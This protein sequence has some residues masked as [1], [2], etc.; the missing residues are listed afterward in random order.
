MSYDLK[1]FTIVEVGEDSWGIQYTGGPLERGF[2][3]Y[4]DALYTANQ[5]AI[6]YHSAD[7]DAVPRNLDQAILKAQ[8]AR[9][10]YIT[11]ISENPSA[12]EEEKN[13]EIAKIAAA[14]AYVSEY[15]LQLDTARL[16]ATAKDSFENQSI[17]IAIAN[18]DARR[19]E[20][21]QAAAN[22]RSSSDATP[23]QIQAA[24]Q[25]AF[26]AELY[27]QSL[28]KEEQSA[29]DVANPT[30]FGLGS[31][32]SSV[33]S[34]IGNVFN[35][36]NNALGNL[37]NPLNGLLSNVTSGLGNLSG[38]LGSVNSNSTGGTAVSGNVVYDSATGGMTNTVSDQRVRLTPKP[39]QRGMLSGVLAPLAATSGLVFPYTPTI[40][41]QAG[42]AYNKIDVVHTNQDWNVYKNTES[43]ALDINGTFTAQNETEAAYFL[44][45]I[46]FLRALTKM[47]FGD[48]SE[49]KGLPPPQVLLDGYGTHMFNSLSVIVVNYSVDLNPNVDYVAVRG[50]GGTSW[51]PAVADLRVNVIVQQTPKQARS[52]NWESFATGELMSNGGWL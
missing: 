15:Q 43:I 34:S 40:T 30:A 1:T 45:A 33:S 7:T 41:Y 18:A 22:L 16:Q 29:I 3:S 2:A 32:F 4:E 23:E 51:V 12:T 14:E 19:S 36:A 10:N 9:D 21:S 47:H 31:L 26:E 49:N 50:D 46:H 6:N 39:S 24:D 5:A 25:S 11:F 44:A 35:S 37:T 38:G 28:I 17:D 52:F 20:L 8:E 13:E 42:V 27:Y 48:S